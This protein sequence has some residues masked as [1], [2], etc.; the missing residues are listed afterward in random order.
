MQTEYSI[1]VT[2]IKNR[3]H[4]RLFRL[5]KA[6]D[7][8]A[9]ELRLDIGYVCRDML[10]TV[11]KCGC[12]D[13]FTSAARYRNKVGPIGKIFWDARKNLLS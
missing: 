3:Y 2:K 9:C 4:C 6:I 10:R 13:D 12:G 8:V 11:D 5:D 7:E 1:K